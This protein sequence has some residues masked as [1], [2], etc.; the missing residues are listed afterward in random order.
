M[1]QR[2]AASRL[3]LQSCPVNESDR[4]LS[5]SASAVRPL[6]LDSLTGLRFFAALLV[7][8]LHVGQNFA[9]PEPVKWLT[10]LGYTGVTFFFVLSGFVLIWSTKVGDCKRGFYGRRFARVWPAHVATTLLSIPVVYLSGGKP[11]WTALP[12]VLLMIHAWIPDSSW[13]TAFNGPSWSLSVEA[14]FYSVFPVLAALALSSARMRRWLVVGAV[15]LLVG[16]AALTVCLTPETRWGYLLYINPLYRIGEFTLGIAAGLVVKRGFNVAIPLPAAVALIP[17][18]Y[19]L[20]LTFG[21]RDSQGVIPLVV[22]NSAM[23]LPFLAL[24]VSAAKS[25]LDLTR[26]AFR[27]RSIVMLGER[28]FGLYLVHLP[29]VCIFSGTFRSWSQYRGALAFTTF[30]VI[31]VSMAAAHF[32]FIYVER[33]AERYLRRALG[34]GRKSPLPDAGI[35]HAP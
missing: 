32:L 31:V 1:G 26:N 11:N 17:A 6:R 35:A 25:D 19:L 23:L 28:S 2:T 21:P 30:G 34:V 7:V 8:L 9:V 15:S 14:F 33:P 24:I 4:A 3:H 22:A 27:S 18:T 12:F 13:Y 10:S 5:K 16:G 20:T 29:I